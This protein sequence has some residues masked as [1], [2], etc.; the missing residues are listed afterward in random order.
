M[1]LVFLVRVA[2]SLRGGRFRTKFGIVLR[3]DSTNKFWTL[4]AA[5]TLV[6]IGLLAA[7]AWVWTSR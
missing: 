5:N 7:Q 2:L 1:G 6:G 4:V 3:R